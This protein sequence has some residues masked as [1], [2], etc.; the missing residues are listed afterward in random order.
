MLKIDIAFKNYCDIHWVFWIYLNV[1]FVIIVI[2]FISLFPS[3]TKRAI[4]VSFTQTFQ[5]ELLKSTI[6]PLQISS[7]VRLVKLI[8]L[9]NTVEVDRKLTDTKCNTLEK[10]LKVNSQI[11][12]CNWKILLQGLGKSIIYQ[13]ISFYNFRS[14]YYLTKK[15][16]IFKSKRNWKDT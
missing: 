8:Y 12:Y 7:V 6:N 10:F 5:L 14:M 1:Y 4:Y 16:T 15:L 3:Y 11:I 9:L 13:F 2:K